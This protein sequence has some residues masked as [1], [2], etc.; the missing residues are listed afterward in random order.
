M[1]RS[2]VAILI[3]ALLACCAQD[4]SSK[5]ILLHGTWTAVALKDLASGTIEYKSQANTFNGE[6]WID[7]D[8]YANPPKFS[9]LMIVNSFAGY[10]NYVGGQKLKRLEGVSLTEV[11]NNPPWEL[12]FNRVLYQAEIPFAIQN[13]SLMMYYSNGTKAFVFKKK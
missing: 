10:Y 12:Q 9:G 4:E 1:K 3:V 7:F 6:L 8:D 13:D 11:G 5:V 2:S